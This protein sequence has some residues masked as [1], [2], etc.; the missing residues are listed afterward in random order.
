MRK[1]RLA[2]DID[3]TICTNTMGRYYEAKPFTDM[4]DYIN[5][6]HDA[7]HYI[8]FSIGLQLLSLVFLWRLWKIT[9]FF[10]F[11]YNRP[12]SVR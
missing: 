2:F 9:S 7:G 6:M 3:G 4:I 5:E 8:I 10:L 11:L 12:G 1:L